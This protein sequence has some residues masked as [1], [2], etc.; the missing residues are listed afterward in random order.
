MKKISGKHKRE[1]RASLEEDD[2]ASKRSNMADSVELE[3]MPNVAATQPEPNLNDIKEMLVEIQITVTMILRENQE[4]KQEILELKSALSANQRDKEKLKTQLSKAKK[5]NDT[6]RNELSHTRMKLND[7][8]E[9]TNRLDEKYDYLEHY[10]R[11]NLL[12]ILG[13]PNYPN[14]RSHK[15]QDQTG[16][17]RNITQTQK[18][19]Y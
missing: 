7:Q 10:S 1:E 16:E 2:N 9:E 13:V 11:K 12:E 17:Y 18:E 4:L 19:K 3:G 6:L 5:A 15:R 8:I 14:W